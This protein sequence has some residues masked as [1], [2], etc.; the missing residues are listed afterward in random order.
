MSILLPMQLNCGS[1]DY[2]LNMWPIVVRLL[3]DW[4]CSLSLLCCLPQPITYGIFV[5]MWLGTQWKNQGKFLIVELNLE[6]GG[7]DKFHAFLRSYKAIYHRQMMWH[8]W[9]VKV[10]WFYITEMEH[11]VSYEWKIKWKTMQRCKSKGMK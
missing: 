10:D 8:I 11:I 4:D 2:F 9:K 6:R 3:L 1:S 7:L 5:S